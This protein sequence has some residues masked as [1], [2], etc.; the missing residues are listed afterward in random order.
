MC[1]WSRPTLT[2]L[3]LLPC[4]VDTTDS[5]QHTTSNLQSAKSNLQ[6]QKADEDDHQNWLTLDL[7][8]TYQDFSWNIIRL[9]Y[10]SIMRAL[11]I[12]SDGTPDTEFYYILLQIRRKGLYIQYICTAGELRLIPVFP[13]KLKWN[14]LISKTFS[15]HLPDS[16]GVFFM[17]FYGW[18]SSIIYKTGLERFCQ[19]TTLYSKTF[20]HQ[21]ILL[22]NYSFKFMFLLSFFT[23]T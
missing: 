7:V 8:L 15:K 21:I 12:C 19:Q 9:Y 23:M 10:C 11:G 1:W 13:I 5:W 22:K 16:W 17:D 20:S 4:I 6:L 2:P 14:I 18:Y 3:D